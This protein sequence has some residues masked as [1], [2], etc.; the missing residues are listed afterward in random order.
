MRKI[1]AVLSFAFLAAVMSSSAYAQATRTWVSGVGDDANPCSR[2]APCKTF[3]GAISK[4][5]TRGEISVLDPGGFGSVT[6]TKAINITNDNSGEAGILAA[7]TNGININVPAGT[8]VNLRGLV[9][10]GAGTG[11][12]GVRILQGGVVH[13]QNSVIRNFQSGA[14]IGINV[15]PTAATEL[16]VSDTLIADNQSGST[17]AGIQVQPSGTGSANIVLTRV[18]LDRNAT[19]ILANGAGSTGGI[20]I[21]ATDTVMAGSI[22]HGIIASSPVGGSAI[23]AQFDRS[24]IAFNLTNGVRSSGSGAQILLSNTQVTGNGTGLS[25]VGGG[26]LL[27]FQNNYVANNTTNGTF[28]GTI[29][30]Q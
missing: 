11:L 15:T 26:Q 4:T 20:R 9:I 29:A 10:E 14:A 2:T 28:S 12:A 21:S 23:T 8:A 27:T 6:I 3:A 7:S 18:L 22:V 16:Y 19:G 25:F 13:I 30:Q 24:M 1:I 17:G 5:A